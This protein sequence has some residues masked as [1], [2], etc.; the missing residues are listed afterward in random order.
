MNM[1]KNPDEL[2]LRIPAILLALTVH[3]YAHGWIA[4]LKGDSTARNAGRL[5]LNPFDHIDVFGFLM[6]MLGPFGWAKPVPVNPYNLDN[7]GRDMVYVSIAGPASN[8]LLAL[9]FGY[10]L[11][12]LNVFGVIPVTNHYIIDFLVLSVTINLGLSFFNLLP[13]PPLDGS[14][15]L[16]GILPP[17]R[18]VKYLSIVQH[19]P[20]IFLILILLEWG[21]HIPVFSFLI[22]P[23][24]KPF[25]A[26]WQFVIFGGKVL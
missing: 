16:M 10:S 3:E 18:A 1:F 24:W 4:W 7:P 9:L 13:V 8:I 6:M 21:L 17:T 23:L 26:F 15:I 20:K 5:T 11:R 19:A 22:Y 14:R 12:L 25:N 2:L